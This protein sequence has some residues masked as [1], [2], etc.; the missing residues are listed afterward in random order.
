M[1]TTTEWANSRIRNARKGH[2]AL[3]SELLGIIS[4]NDTLISG[5]D[6]RLDAKCMID[7]CPIWV[8]A[9]TS[10]NVQDMKSQKMR[11][12][13]GSLD[14]RRRQRRWARS[15]VIHFLIPQ[16]LRYKRSTSVSIFR[17]LQ[18]IVVPARQV[19]HYVRSVL[20]IE[21]IVTLLRLKSRS[22]SLY[23]I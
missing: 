1:T 16:M 4:L 5:F 15:A 22:S 3:S 20:S 10:E 19:N 13:E 17:G 23:C 8:V 2:V 18:E 21:N 9:G 7:W 11:L 14:F 6:A 12:E